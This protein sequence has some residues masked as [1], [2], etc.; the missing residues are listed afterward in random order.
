MNYLSEIEFIPQD[1]E[2][3]DKV[4]F[5][6]PSFTGV[7]LQDYEFSTLGSPENWLTRDDAGDFLNLIQCLPALLHTP[8]QAS[9][10][11]LGITPG[12]TINTPQR[13]LTL[14]G[15]NHQSW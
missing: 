11:I 6:D 15:P 1:K 14:E 7:S 4:P 3:P 13:Q 12:L 5:P 9:D 10:L 8:A 2:M